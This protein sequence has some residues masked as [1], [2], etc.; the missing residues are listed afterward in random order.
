MAL[1]MSVAVTGA[2][3]LSWASASSGTERAAVVGKNVGASFTATTVTLTEPSSV[4][5][6]SETR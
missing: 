6:P 1:S 4:S 5:R 2:P 3:T